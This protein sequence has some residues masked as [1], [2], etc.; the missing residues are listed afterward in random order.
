MRSI[1]LLLPLAA[2][3][4]APVGT[5]VANGP[6]N[7]TTAPGGPP[8]VAAVGPGRGGFVVRMTDGARCRA[9]RPEGINTGW[10]GT[11]TDCAYALPY[12]VAFVARTP[13]GRFGIEEGFGLAGQPRAEVFVTDTDGQRKLYLSPLGSIALAEGA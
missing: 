8:R 3:A 6:T 10:S 1:L 5:T 2:A 13:P 7:A 12:T 4:C 9:L 11:T